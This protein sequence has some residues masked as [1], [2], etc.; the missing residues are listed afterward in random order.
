MTDQA[1]R[2]GCVFLPQNPPERLAATARIA[3][4]AGLEELW[5]WEDCF[6]PAVSAA[7]I[8]LSNSRRLTVG[9]GVAPV[10]MRN[11]R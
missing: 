6:W 3:D 8:A 5:V 4:D 9:I 1:P 7:A 2:L 10:P 11:P